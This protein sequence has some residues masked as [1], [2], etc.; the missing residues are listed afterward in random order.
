MWAADAATNP[1]PN[2]LRD[3]GCLFIA[4]YVGTPYQRYGVSRDYIDQC[5]SVGVGVMLIFEEWASQFLGGYN[6]AIQ[7]CN[8]MM[9]AW[10]ALG[11]PRDGS[12]IPAVVILDPSPSAAYGNE[13]ALQDFARG[14]NDA[15]PFNEFTGYGSRYSLDLAGAVAPKMTRRW[16][17]GTWGYGERGDGSLPGDVPADMI[18]HGNRGAPVARC[19]YN[20]IFREDMGQWGGPAVAK[21]EDDPFMWG[22]VVIGLDGR[23][24]AYAVAGST[25][26][27]EFGGAPGAYGIP[28]EAIDS[29]LRLIRVDDKPGV[30][31]WKSGWDRLAAA[32]NFSV[33][34]PR[35]QVTVGGVTQEQQAAVN[36]SIEAAKTLDAQF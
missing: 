30:D 15:L 17:V 1:D 6:A 7:S 24:H 8:R 28:Q 33:V 12:V 34:D 31:G 18:Q 14:W 5:L 20:T 11:A 13:G 9:A 32:S 23:V 22:A 27:Y 21:K 26:L 2:E 36:A 29:G 19:D 16:G 35:E 10:D 25:I 4:R 3:T